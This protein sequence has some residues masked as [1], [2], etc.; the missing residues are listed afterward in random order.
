MVEVGSEDKGTA[1]GQGQGLSLNELEEVQGLLAER[2]RLCGLLGAQQ[3]APSRAEG[4][5][6]EWEAKEGELRSVGEVKRADWA[7]AIWRRW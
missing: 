2:L 4:N 5:L 3:A 7:R 1:K 6:R